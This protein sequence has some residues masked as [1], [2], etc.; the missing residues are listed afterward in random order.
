MFL[1]AIL[2]FAGILIG[3]IIAHEVGHFVVAKL[4]GV[5]VV[6]VGLGY[7]PRIWGK[8]FH[9]TIYS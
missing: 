5:R 3:L 6:E 7:P 9:G 8:E 4:T 1:Q 2:P